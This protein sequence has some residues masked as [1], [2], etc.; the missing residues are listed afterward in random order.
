VIALPCPLDERPSVHG[1]S[2][3]VPVAVTGVEAY[4]VDGA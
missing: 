1:P 4:G 3:L 2:P